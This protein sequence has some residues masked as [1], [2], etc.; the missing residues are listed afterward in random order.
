[1]LDRPLGECLSAAQ[2]RVLA[3]GRGDSQHRELRRHPLT[4]AADPV[5]VGIG[6]TVRQR[7]GQSIERSRISRHVS[8]IR[9]HQDGI[10]VGQLAVNP[11]EPNEL[12]RC[13]LTDSTLEALELSLSRHHTEDIRDTF[14]PAT[15]CRVLVTLRVEVM[16]QTGPE[17]QETNHLG[18]DV[19]VDHP[20]GAVIEVGLE[21]QHSLTVAEVR[22]DA[23]GTG[24]VRLAIASGDYL[25]AVSE[26]YT[27]Q[28]PSL[29]DIGQH[30]LQVRAS[31]IA[32]IEQQ[33]ATALSASL[34]LVG[35]PVGQLV[36]E[37]L[38]RREHIRSTEVFDQ[39]GRHVFLDDR[40]TQFLTDLVDDG[41]FTA[42]RS[43][44]DSDSALDGIEG[45]ERSLEKFS[46]HRYVSLCYEC[47]WSPITT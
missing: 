13:T 4:V 47:L 46:T 38:T 24:T 40:N 9:V 45:L 7:T 27:M 6:S 34:T 32:I 29:T 3:N 37:R 2:I 22:E 36:A 31:L 26:R 5:E 42:A 21:L 18:L 12:S 14:D 43:A 35:I 30:L 44:F 10:R 23:V 25:P 19:V 17:P 33:N 11:H 28:S 15:R 1:M 20:L 8:R 16:Q 41:R 39:H